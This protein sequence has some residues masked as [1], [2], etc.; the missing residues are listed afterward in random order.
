[1][2]RPKRVGG[3]HDIYLLIGRKERPKRVNKR[4]SGERL[5]VSKMAGYERMTVTSDVKS[6]NMVFEPILEEGVLR[7]DCSADD[8]NVA[9]PSLSFVNPK[10]RETPIMTTDKAPSF[11]P[12]FECV[13][14]QQIV[15]LQVS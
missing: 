14:G 2:E 7:F 6:G 13:L 9:L 4:L 3:F 12:T 1:K 8:R 11:T 10:D 5:V 15:N